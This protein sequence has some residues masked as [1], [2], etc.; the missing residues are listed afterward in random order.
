MS[1]KQVSGGSE[2]DERLAALLTNANAIS[3][4]AQAVEGTIGPKGLDT[5][6]VDR[7]GDVVITNAGV[8]ILNKMSQPSCGAHVDQ[9]C[10]SPAG[11]D[12]RRHD[13]RHDHA[14]A[15]VAE[16]VNQVERRA[17]GAGNRGLK[18]GLRLGI[19]SCG[20]GHVNSR[21]DDP[22]CDASPIS[23]R[24]AGRHCRSGSGGRATRRLGE[25]AGEIFQT[26]RHHHRP[27]R[28]GE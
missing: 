27:G 16:G 5:M 2:V 22:S 15:L 4:V 21:L 19:E 1:L 6:L 28:G 8:T 17:S 24:G 25:V 12:R 20:G 7:F 14:G 10:Q 13:H 18:L 9:C 23:G 11:G 3:A 26:G